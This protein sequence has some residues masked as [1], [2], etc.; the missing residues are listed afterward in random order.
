MNRFSFVVIAISCATAAAAAGQT[1][2]AISTRSLAGDW[3]STVNPQAKLVLHLH[4]DAGGALS[5]AI[6]V[7]GSP[8]K[9]IVLSNTCLAGNLLTFTMPPMKGNVIE[10]ILPGARRMAG[11]YMWVKEGTTEL[12]PPPPFE[13]LSQLAG[14]WESPGVGPSPLVLRLRLNARGALTGAIDVPEPM[15]Q[16][17]TLKDVKVSGNLLSYTM[18]DGIHTYQGAF[19]KDGRTVQATGM[20]TIDASWHHVRT[21]ALAASRD[22]A[23]NADPANG[24]WTGVG[25]YTSSFPGIG[26]RKGTV[27]LTFHFRSNPASCLAKLEGNDSAVPCQMTVTGNT[28]HVERVIGYEATFVGTLS[29]DRNHLSGT[30]TMGKPWHWTG[31]MRID[32]ARVGASLGQ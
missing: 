3:D 12:P 6:D 30:W 1:A 16:R 9:R 7:P 20:S 18:P 5:G 14:D 4:V 24:D 22:A 25:N 2:P 11:P 13:P 26:P 17:L 28:V 31:P 23:A 21:A 29:P 15:T 27:K 32:L 19:S 8:P 10:V